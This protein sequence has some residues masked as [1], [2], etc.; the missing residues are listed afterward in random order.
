M[1]MNWLQKIN[2]ISILQAWAMLWVVIGH[3][4][5][6]AAAE[7]QPRYAE[8]LYHIA[9][10]FHMP[11]FIFVSG[12]L[13]YLTRIERPMPYLRMIGDKLKRLGIPFL[14]FTMIAMVIKTRFAEDMTRPSSIGLQEFVH[15]I[16]YPG[17]G[18]LS[19]LW[20]LTA[21]GWMFILRPLWTWSLNGKYATAATVALLTAIHLYA[22]K[23]IEFLALSSAMRYVLFFYLGM[24]AC[25]Y[26]IVDRFAVAYKTI[27]VI[28]GSIYVASIFLDFALL[29]ALSGIALS[30]SLALLADRFV[31]QL[32]AG[33]R[34]YT[35]QIYLISI[36][37]QV[38]VK[39]L[40]KHDLITHY[41]TGYVVC[42]LAGIYVPVLIAATAKKLN[43]RF[44]NL[45]LGLSK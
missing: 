5:L 14:V 7:P 40:Y 29:S 43:I 2:W 11:L 8:L 1:T 13:F 22:P 12:Y 25:K 16:L 42:I 34:N 33:F 3:A 28:A 20:F 30:V 9:Y 23:G 39:I 18:P 38:L 27:L 31:P 24:I 32:F 19:E 10:S 21:I 15:N 45:C 44:I 17:E 37:V 4:P 35:Y 6:S 26:R 36:F 41:A